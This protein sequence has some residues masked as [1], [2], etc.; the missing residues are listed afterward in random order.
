MRAGPLAAGDCQWTVSTS[1]DRHDHAGVYD[2]GRRSLLADRG[3]QGEHRLD[4][5]LPMAPAGRCELR[6]RAARD[7]GEAGGGGEVRSPS[8]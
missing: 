8:P 4:R 1:E 3:A 5:R 2:R 6:A 7:H